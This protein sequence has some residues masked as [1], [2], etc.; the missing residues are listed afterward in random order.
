LVAKVRISEQKAKEKAIFLLFFRW[1]V[2]LEQ[3]KGAKKVK[4]EK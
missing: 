1:K 2:P 3:A 4:S